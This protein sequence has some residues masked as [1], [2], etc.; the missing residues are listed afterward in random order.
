MTV[1]E[2]GKF[3]KNF[4]RKTGTNSKLVKIPH[5]NIVGYSKSDVAIIGDKIDA[6][7][8]NAWEKFLLDKKNDEKTMENYPDYQHFLFA[9]NNIDDTDINKYGLPEDFIVIDD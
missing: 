2:K 5:S 7:Y 9:L 1:L 4:V 8:W 6:S 3:I